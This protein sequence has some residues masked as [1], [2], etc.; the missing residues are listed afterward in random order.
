M[1]HLGVLL[2]EPRARQ[3][4]VEEETAEQDRRRVGTRDA[5]GEERDERGAGDGVVRGFRRGDAL[6]RAVSRT[7]PVGDQRLASL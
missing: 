4:P 7:P 1:D 6:R 2:E 3:Q 5:E